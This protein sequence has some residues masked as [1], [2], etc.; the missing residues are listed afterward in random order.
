MLQPGLDLER[1]RSSASRICSAAAST[2]GFDRVASASSASSTSI[3]V[4]VGLE[5]GGGVGERGAGPRRCDGLEQVAECGGHLLDGAGQL[6]AGGVG[7]RLEGRTLA[8]RV[9]ERGDRRDRLVVGKLDVDQA[10]V[11]QRLHHVRGLEDGEAALGG[12]LGDVAGAVDLAE[13]RPVG[14]G[15]DDV[16]GSVRTRRQHRDAPLATD[17]LDELAPAVAAHLDLGQQVAHG[18]GGATSWRVF[19]VLRNLWAATGHSSRAAMASR[20]CSMTKASTTGAFDVAEVDE[21]LTEPPA[22]QLVGLD[23]EGGGECL[24]GEV[25]GGDQAGA[26]LGAASRHEDRV[27]RSVLEVDLGLLARRGR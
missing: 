19:L 6:V 14:A 9:V 1:S 11:H 25:A 4:V 7:C 3:G 22:L 13:Q 20:S 26:E 15:Q 2:L 5:R 8:A 17:R 16:G 27:D 12:E 21:Q 23:V 10:A 24:G 18:L